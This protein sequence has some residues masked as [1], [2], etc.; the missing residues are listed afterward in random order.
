MN[1]EWD[2]EEDSELAKTGYI[3]CKACGTRI[4]A[5]R[6]ACLRCGTPLEAAA[7]TIS[8]STIS[9]GRPLLVTLGIAAVLVVLGGVFWIYRPSVQQEA[10]RPAGPAPRAATASRQPPQAV[11]T[12]TAAVEAA[13]SM[14]GDLLDAQSA[15]I[16][17]SGDLATLQGELE[18]A[19]KQNPRDADALNN[20]AL[21]L[22]KLGDRS[23]AMDKLQ[24]AVEVTQTKW[25]Y[26]FNLGHVRAEEGQWDAASSEFRLAARLQ[27]TDYAT[28]FDLA[29]S[30][31][32]AGNDLAAIAEYQGALQLA[33]DDPQAH[34]G[35]GSSFEK[36]GKLTEAQQEFQQYLTMKPTA[37]DALAVRT[38]MDDLARAAAG[39]EGTP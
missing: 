2:D 28:Q 11:A 5:N 36:A 26:H 22:D 21:V 12:K 32:K 1:P 19:L 33:P 24:R 25:A 23:G 13:P 9:S 30:L 16:D 17:L 4:R 20:L 14:A 15:T 7:E 29:T 10:A 39:R 38:H 37:T 27:P 8:L 34:L 18:Q 6:E 31:H 3:A 35:L